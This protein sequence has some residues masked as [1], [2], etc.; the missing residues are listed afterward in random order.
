[1]ASGQSVVLQNNGGDDE[2][3]SANGKFTFDTKVASG[4]SYAVTIL[5]QPTGQT[6][7][8]SN[9]S[10]SNVMADVDT[11]AVSCATNTYSIGGSVSGLASGQSVVLQNNGGDDLTISD[12]GGF[13]FS[14][15]VASGGSYDVTVLTQPSGQTCTLSNGSG[16][17][18]MADV[19]TVEVSCATNTPSGAQSTIGAD[20]DTTD[21]TPGEDATIVVTVRDSDDDPL[22]GIS[23]ALVVDSA[24]VNAGA[25]SIT[26]TSPTSTNA[27]GEASFVVTSSIPQEVTFKA[28]FNPDL[29]ITIT[30][31]QAPVPNAAPIPTLGLPA[32]G[33]L[34]AL[35][36]ALAGWR[37]RRGSRR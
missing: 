25:V 29:F 18:V 21:V 17:N 14:T 23:V 35:M 34:A 27:Q 10:G 12:N 36:A 4:G 3:V 19:T 22:S 6:C 28:S 30:W 1:L 8:L 16:S 9:A 5:T 13:T 31:S 20:G 32:L 15:E 37:Q 2:T 11:V 24:S 33:A 26:T 7:T